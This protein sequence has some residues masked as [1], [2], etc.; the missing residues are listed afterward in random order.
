MAHIFNLGVAD[1]LKGLTKRGAFNSEEEAS[2]AALDDD[3]L[4]DPI[5]ALRGLIVAVSSCRDA[6]MNTDL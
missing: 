1:L 4:K 2:V 6:R 3:E 5:V